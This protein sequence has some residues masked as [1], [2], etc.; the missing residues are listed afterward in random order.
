MIAC[1]PPIECSGI[2]VGDGLDVGD[3]GSIDE[4]NEGEDEE[5]EADIVQDVVVVDFREDE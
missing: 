5:D 2:G 4:E 3:T 1:G